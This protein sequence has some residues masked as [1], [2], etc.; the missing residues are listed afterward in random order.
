MYTEDQ[1]II[2]LTKKYAP[3]GF[4][5]R[6]VQ[7]TPT[8]EVSLTGMNWSE[9]YKTSYVAVNLSSGESA[10]FPDPEWN[11]LYQLRTVKMQA[12]I[13]II[14][15]QWAG[16]SK[17]VKVYLHPSNL[18][19]QIESAPALTANQLALLY[20]TRAYKNTYGGR[21]DIRREEAGRA[22]YRL[23]SEEW[24]KEQSVL[25]EMGYLDRRGSL[26]TKGK[27]AAPNKLDN[28][29]ENETSMD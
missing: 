29:Y 19:Q 24:A 13:A 4:S 12:G 23:S 5:K 22:G 18:T 16:L 27:N 17:F 11:E 15:Y 8:E 2:K 20:C 3:E 10:D 14:A 1:T 9:G 6:Q 26:T 25:H 21:T 28:H 7:V